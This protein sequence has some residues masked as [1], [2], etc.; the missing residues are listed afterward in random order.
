MINGDFDSP[1]FSNYHGG[2][3]SWYGVPKAG[4]K[5]GVA[6]YHLSSAY[7]GGGYGY[8]KKYNSDFIRISES[9][10]KKLF[11]NRNSSE[12]N[13]LLKVNGKGSYHICY[14]YNLISF[15]CTY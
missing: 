13:N 1:K 10:I 3:N 12:V 7:L 9:V 15:M 8:W 14:S 11:I 4:N 5:R 6:P 2:Q